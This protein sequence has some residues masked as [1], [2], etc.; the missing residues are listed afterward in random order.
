MD[1]TATPR[2]TFGKAVK[3]LKKEGLIP[4]ELYGKG[5]KNQHLAVKSD[6]FR[7]VYK[8][9]GEN[10]VVTILVGTAKEPALIYDVVRDRL[11]GEISH[12]DFYKVNMSEKI[13]THVPLVFVGDAPAVKAGNVLNKTLSEIEVEALPGD[14]PHD[15]KVDVSVLAAVDAAIYVKD[16]KVPKG[17]KVLIDAD[18]V[19][20]SVSEAREE[21]VAPV[22]PADVTEVVV[23]TEE[24]KAERDAAK[25][26]EEGEQA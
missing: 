26:A 16:L 4:A 18:M 22:A 25:A 5:I 21:E 6:E 7:R 17:V 11:S 14:L 10:T 2:T 12:I 3:T 20:I 23:E 15:I 24:K 8:E 9:A 1:L 19:V 13:T